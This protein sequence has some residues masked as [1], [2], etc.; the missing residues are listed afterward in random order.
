M[1]ANQQQWNAN[2]RILRDKL[3]T[4][5]DFAQM[6]PLLLAHH[7]MTHMAGVGPS[8]LWSYAD[9]VWTGISDS[10]AR[11][12]PAKFEH[13]FAWIFLH[14]ARIEDITMNALLA[15]TPELFYAE[16][17]QSALNVPFAH[18]G[19]EISDSDMVLL[20]EQVDVPALRAYRAAVGRR[21]QT[22][23]AGLS[24]EDMPKKVD[25]GRIQALRQSDSVLPE[26]SG[27]I[28]YWSK[29]NVAGLL[30]MPPTRHNF[31]HL[32]EAARIKSA[33]D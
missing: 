14:L 28:D 23:I 20:N 13:S 15:G 19:N 2:Q 9:E 18:T 6:Q 22:I 11:R 4:G 31:I 7:A 33:F 32:N 26:A 5:E 30:L 16:N 3:P 27:V 24:A 21:T 10:D 17:W 1:D 25:A 8:G 29:R 12:I